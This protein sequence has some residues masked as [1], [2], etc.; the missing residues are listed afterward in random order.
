MELNPQD[1]LN[2]DGCHFSPAFAGESE[3]APSKRGPPSFIVF[4]GAD[5]SCPQGRWRFLCH[6][7]NVE[8]PGMGLGKQGWGVCW[9]TGQ[10]FVSQ[11][12]RGEQEADQGGAGECEGAQRVGQGMWG[13]G[14]K[15]KRCRRRLRR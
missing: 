13:A 9:E 6:Q 12:S 14:G 7:E 2:Q 3:A 8:R 5:T 10:E 15:L 1:A 11:N 4:N